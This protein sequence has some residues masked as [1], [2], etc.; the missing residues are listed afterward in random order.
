MSLN[1]NRETNVEINKEIP[2]TD[3]KALENLTASE[4]IQ[5]LEDSETEAQKS[6]AENILL[7][8]WKGKMFEACKT[9]KT[10]I[11]ELLLEH[12]NCEESGHKML[13]DNTKLN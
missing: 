12:Y 3:E 9:G 2:Q 8:K 5:G 13:L 11:V 1:E 6:L 4:L 7:E 10:R